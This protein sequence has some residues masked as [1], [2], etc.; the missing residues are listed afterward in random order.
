MSA[1]DGAEQVVPENHFRQGLYCLGKTFNNARHAYLSL[2]LS[3][4]NLNNINVRFSVLIAFREFKI[5]ST[6]RM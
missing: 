2:K 6:C 1:E 5:T 4:L 3:S